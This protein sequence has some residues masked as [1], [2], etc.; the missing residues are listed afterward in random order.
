MLFGSLLAKQIKGY[1]WNSTKR[2]YIILQK[3]GVKFYSLVKPLRKRLYRAWCILIRKFFYTDRKLKMN[4][5]MVKAT[6][7][8]TITKYV[9]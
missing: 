6:E 2:D 5:N 4:L 1:L 8:K 3:G 7:K 9:E